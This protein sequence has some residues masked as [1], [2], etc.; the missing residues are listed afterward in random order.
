MSKAAVFVLTSVREGLPNVMIEAL[1]CGCP[2]VSTDCRSGP[3]EIL[4]GG[5]WGRL[6]P[7]GDVKALSEAIMA[8]IA[9]PPDRATLVERARFFSAAAIARRYLS[10]LLPGR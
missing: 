1:A 4:E 6:V 9:Q 7:V 8:A 10:E 5:T 3:A 2:V